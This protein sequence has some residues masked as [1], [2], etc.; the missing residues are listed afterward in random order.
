MGKVINW[1][2]CKWLKFGHADKWYIHEPES[3]QK[4][5]DIEFCVTLKYKPTIK[6]QPEDHV[7]EQIGDRVKPT[8]FNNEKKN[9]A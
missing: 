9:S 3:I 7:T 2:L 4:N 5:W 1:E 6:S 8:R